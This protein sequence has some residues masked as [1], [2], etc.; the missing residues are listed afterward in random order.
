MDRLVFMKFRR[1]VLTFF[2][3]YAV[4]LAGCGQKGP[5]YLPGEQPPGQAGADETAEPTE[6]EAPPAGTRPEAG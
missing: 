2:C 4:G 6:P 3:L 5:L 1:A